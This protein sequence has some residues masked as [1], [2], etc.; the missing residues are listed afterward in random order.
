MASILTLTLNPAIDVSTSV[1]RLEPVHKLRCGPVRRDPG[2]GGINVARVVRRLGSDVIAVYPE[3]GLIGALLR[4]LTD[5]EG[6]QS[7]TVA[8]AEETREDFTVLDHASGEQFRFVLPGPHVSEPEWRSC[9]HQVS[10]LEAP[11]SFIV[12]SGSLP[13]GVPP[14][15]F[16]VLAD[17]A[18][19]RGAKL[20]VDGTKPVLQAALKRGVHLIKPSLREMR[21]LMDEPLAS[22]SE[23]VDACRRLV[24]AGGA[25]FVALTLGEG[26]ALL[27]GREEAWF[28]PGLP[29]KLVSAVGAGDSFLGAFVWALNGGH[30]HHEALRHAIAA[31]SAALLRPATDL[32]RKE[33]VERLLPSV[34]IE[35]V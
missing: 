26:G 11:V 24:A 27:V 18:Q 35:P 23:W 8:T 29:V 30:T 13:P 6:V 31:G 17:L 1:E 21:D 5:A 32:C 14:D 9:L 12:A 25:E 33:D 7:R 20:V 3:G 2:G 4:K 34:T 16:S 28:A 19:E 15:V 22:K 10:S